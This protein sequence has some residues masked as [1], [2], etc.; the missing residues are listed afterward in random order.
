[1]LAGD[2]LQDGSKG[3]RVR[4]SGGRSTVIDGP[5]PAP[6]PEIDLR[7]RGAPD[8]PGYRVHLQGGGYAIGARAWRP[9]WRAHRA[10]NKS[11]TSATTAPTYP[12][13]E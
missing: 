13:P 5:G 4:F 3:A 7:V 6:I 8:V 2:G 12:T 9:R 11:G 10:M 1:M